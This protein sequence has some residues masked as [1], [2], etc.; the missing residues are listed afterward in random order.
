ML[1]EMADS[2]MEGGN[3]QNERGVPCSAKKW[4]STHIH[5]CTYMYI[6]THTNTNTE[7][8]FKGRQEATE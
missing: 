1:G 7:Q 4:W 5:M 8:Y 2:G 3:T 6:C